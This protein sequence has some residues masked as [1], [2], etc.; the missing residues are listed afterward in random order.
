MAKDSA[1]NAVK[2]GDF[3]KVSGVVSTN[4]EETVI[5][6]VTSLRETLTK[7]E[8]KGRYINHEGH[9]DQVTFDPA[10]CEL[11]KL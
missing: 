9:V 5:A 4:I 2:L 6:R 3:V 1:G 10:D 7:G 8:A 11:V